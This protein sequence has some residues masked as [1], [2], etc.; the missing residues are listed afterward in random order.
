MTFENRF[1]PTQDPL[2]EAP[3]V[4]AIDFDDELKAREALLAATRLGRKRS[5]EMTDAAIVTRTPTGRTRILQTRDTSPAQGAVTGSWL[6]G[7][8]GLLLGGITGWVI[9]LAIGVLGGWLWA[10]TRDLG[11]N[12]P[13]M[14]RTA[15]NLAPGH[16]VAF[17]QLPQVY[18]THLIRELRRFDGTLLHNSLRD[19]PTV[20][21]EEALAA[22]P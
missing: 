12:D 7:L 18:V 4:L 16:A 1:Q 19:V 8:A 9:G 5:V 21:L 2:G 20:E 22:I 11:I 17:F 13:W 6:G 3:D 15:A 10:K 14:R